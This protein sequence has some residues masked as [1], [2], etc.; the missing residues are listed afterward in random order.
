MLFTMSLILVL[1]HTLQFPQEPSC[2]ISPEEAVVYVAPPE[3]RHTVVG[4]K[5]ISITGKG[6]PKIE[7]ARFPGPGRAIPQFGAEL[8]SSTDGGKTWKRDRILNDRGDVVLGSHSNPNTSYKVVDGRVLRSADSGKTWVPRQGRIAG[9]DA[10]IYAQAALGTLPKAVRWQLA[11]VHPLE[12]ATIYG[13]LYADI[14]M[15]PD[16][17]KRVPVKGL[18]VSRNGGD[19]W[20][21]FS[22]DAIG[23]E[24]DAQHP[25]LGISPSE[26]AVMVSHNSD[27]LV[28]TT[29]GGKTWGPVGQ[30]EY[31]TSAV[32]LADPEKSVER[33]ANAGIPAPQPNWNGLDVYSVVFH[34]EDSEVIY[35]GTSKGIYRSTDLGKSWRLLNVPVRTLFGTDSVVL[36]PDDPDEV[37]VGGISGAFLSHDAGCHFKKIYP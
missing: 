35:L 15:S 18:Y 29:D 22:H 21:I 36:N 33:L 32:K 5:A 12:P 2:G 14:P 34:P 4:A 25:L 10:L 8:L 27:G 30:N 28:I 13:A 9:V 16:G 1:A 37:L 7:L 26:P 11:N 31:L 6:R 17:V 3:Y 19:N 23:F 24:I 20:D